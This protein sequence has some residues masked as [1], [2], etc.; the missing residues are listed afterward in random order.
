MPGFI[1]NNIPVL[2]D[3][4]PQWHDEDYEARNQLVIE[5]LQPIAKE[6]SSLVFDGHANDAME[7][8]MKDAN[9]DILIVGA[10]GRGFFERIRLGSKS[11]HQVFNSPHHVLVLRPKSTA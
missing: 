11:F 2:S 1:G 5:M 3:L 7:Q 10:Q 9:A 8:A 6:F 4:V